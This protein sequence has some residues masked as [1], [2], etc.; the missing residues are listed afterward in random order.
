MEPRDKFAAAALTGIIAT[1]MNGEDNFTPSD[2]RPDG[3][4]Y[5]WA[6]PPYRTRYQKLAEEAYHVADAMMEARQQSEPTAQEGGE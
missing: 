1:E 6:K 2:L 4:P 3:T 5:E